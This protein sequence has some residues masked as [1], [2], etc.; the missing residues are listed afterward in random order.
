MFKA[1]ILIISSISDIIDSG[2]LEDVMVSISALSI[3]AK[4]NALF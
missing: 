3:P 2:E 4:H 1:G